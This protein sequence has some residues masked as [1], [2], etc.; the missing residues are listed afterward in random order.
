MSGRKILSS[1]LT[2]RF[3]RLASVVSGESSEGV[4]KIQSHWNLFHGVVGTTTPVAASI[5]RQ[6]ADTDPDVEVAKYRSYHDTIG[7]KGLS[8]VRSS[9]NVC[10]NSSVK[11]HCSKRRAWCWNSAVRCSDPWHI[12][13]STAL[14]SGLGQL[15]EQPRKGVTKSR[16]DRQSASRIDGCTTR[17]MIALWGSISC[18]RLGRSAS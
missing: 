11:V 16:G 15:M 3:D 4:R 5:A 8:E 1:S 7:S 12:S 17:S 6:Q 2:R 18:T 13:N 10:R 14:S 9:G